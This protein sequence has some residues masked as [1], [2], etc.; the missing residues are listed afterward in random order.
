MMVLAVINRFMNNLF[1]MS[2]QPRSRGNSKASS[3]VEKNQLHEP[4]STLPLHSTVIDG[5][6]NPGCPYLAAPPSQNLLLPRPGTK[7]KAWPESTWPALRAR[8]G[9]PPGSMPWFT[10]YDNGSHAV[11]TWT[12]PAEVHNRG[13]CLSMQLDAC[14]RRSWRKTDNFRHSSV[15]PF[16]WS[17]G[18]RFSLSP[19]IS[20]P[21]LQGIESTI[22]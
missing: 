14:S 5:L 6:H 4:L 15:S 18:L 1:V 16:R 7:Y 19:K 20:S 22:L 12:S 11:L 13:K 10:S 8:W 2:P 21:W 9:K 17:G 3:N